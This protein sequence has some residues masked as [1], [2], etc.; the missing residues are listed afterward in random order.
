MIEQADEEFM[1]NLFE[2]KFI[3]HLDT[4]LKLTS[5][6]RLITQTLS[7]IDLICLKPTKEEINIWAYKLQ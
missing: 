1:L 5:N 2:N 7:L 4:N 6:P 3:N